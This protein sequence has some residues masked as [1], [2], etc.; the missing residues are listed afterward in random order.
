MSDYNID[1]DFTVFCRR[2]F[3]PLHRCPKS[4]VNM[5]PVDCPMVGKC[6]QCHV[7]QCCKKNKCPGLRHHYTKYQFFGQAPLYCKCDCR[8]DPPGRPLGPVYPSIAEV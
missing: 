4:G 8:L 7:C 2:C 6:S 1:V 3:D 5:C